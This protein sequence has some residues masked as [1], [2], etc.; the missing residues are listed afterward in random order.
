MWAVAGVL[1]GAFF[2]T[3]VLGF[4]I[5]AHS[6]LAAAV[7][8]GLAAA[9]LVVIMVTGQATALVWTLLGGDLCLTAGVGYLAWNGLTHAH[10]PSLARHTRLLGEH[11]YA[12][13]ALTPDGTVT[14]RGEEWSAKS[15][16]GTVL[17]GGTVEVIGLEGI[18]LEVWGEDAE[19]ID[20]GATQ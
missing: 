4:H 17:K 18:H 11:G 20:K 13:T 2:L 19:S 6:H 10:L 16:N 9:W 5:G 7:L 1:L 15:M 14:V 8:G 12:K 3:S